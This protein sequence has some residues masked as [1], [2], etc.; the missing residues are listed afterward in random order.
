MATATDSTHK[1][2]ARPGCAVPS[3]IQGHHS[4]ETTHRVRGQQRRY[5]S[6]DIASLVLKQFSLQDIH[7]TSRQ[8]YTSFTKVTGYGTDS[9]VNL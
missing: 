3:H 2:R 5:N 1:E 9:L 8:N 7:V 6:L 4:T